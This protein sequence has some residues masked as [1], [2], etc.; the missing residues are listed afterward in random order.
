[1]QETETLFLR[2]HLTSVKKTP[3]SKMEASHQYLMSGES[4]TTVAMTLR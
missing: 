3:A 1:V 2:S 4:T